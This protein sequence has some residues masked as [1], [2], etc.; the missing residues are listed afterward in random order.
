MSTQSLVLFRIVRLSDVKN[1]IESEPHV[2]RGCVE[3]DTKPAF[4]KLE[5]GNKRTAGSFLEAQ[6]THLE[7]VAIDGF[8]HGE[9][10]REVVSQTVFP[11]YYN[12]ARN[13]F[14]AAA[15]NAVAAAAIN[16]LNRDCRD[17]LRLARVRLDFDSILQQ[18]G[19]SV[20]G[21]WVMS[22]DQTIRSRA[23]FSGADLRTQKEFKTMLAAGKLSSV[24]LSYPFPTQ[25]KTLRVNVSRWCAAFFLGRVKLKRGLEF[26]EHLAGFE[27]KPQPASRTSKRRKRSG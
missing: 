23:A 6:I 18:S 27:A 26:M 4:T 10:I 12:R 17:D 1:V 16:R 20:H 5:I 3:R 2:P 15:P 21:A 24:S 8:W 13:V 7:G 14:I 25:D 19:L 11:A 9:P 22:P